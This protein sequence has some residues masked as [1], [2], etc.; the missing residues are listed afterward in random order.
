M[1]EIRDQ[2]KAYIYALLSVFCWSTVASAFKITLRYLHVV[3]LLL[4]AAFVSMICL[5]CII[6]LQ[7]K[8]HLL[9]T[10]TG[11]D[12]LHSLLLGFLNPFL[13]YLVLFKAYSLLPAQMAQP[14]NQIWGIVIVILSI[15]ILKQKI[16]LRS[17]A[18]IVVS[19]FG[20]VLIS[21]GGDLSSLEFKNPLGVGLALGSSVIWS[22]YWLFNARDRLEPIVRLFLNF[23]AGFIF[24]LVYFSLFYSFRVPAAA[25]ILGGIYAGLFE[26]GITFFFWIKALKLSETTDRVSILIYIA[27]FISLVFIHLFVGETILVSSVSGLV[28]I[29]G[30]ILIQQTGKTGKS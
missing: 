29:V 6:V 3:E 24:T 27:P 22:L 7:K 1:N 18:A 28:L 14:L 25:G 15:P 13:Y 11:R 23:G 16:R 4:I 9:K 8:I 30:G 5:F 2:K 17:M 19:F 12:Y 26:M 10:L 20:V 21:T